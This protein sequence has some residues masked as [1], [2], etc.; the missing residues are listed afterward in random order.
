MPIRLRTLFNKCVD[1]LTAR[2][3]APAIRSGSSGSSSNADHA[4]SF[5]AACLAVEVMRCD[6]DATQDETTR[7]V[8]VLAETFRLEPE[9]AA[10]LVDDADA[11]FDA[12][13]CLHEFTSVINQSLDTEQKTHL[14]RS[15]WSIALADGV[16]DA[17]EDHAVRKIASLLHLPHKTFV[18]TRIEARS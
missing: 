6:F 3:D 14:L 15:L 1:D 8:N 7:A 5:A 12:A 11:R 13:T 9:E 17:H 18:A 10:A 2:I 4:T 16:L